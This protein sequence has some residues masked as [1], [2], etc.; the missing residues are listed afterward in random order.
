MLN[1]RQFLSVAALATG[2]STIRGSES[3]GGSVPADNPAHRQY[4]NDLARC[5]P[6][7]IGMPRTSALVTQGFH[8]IAP[9]RVIVLDPEAIAQF[10]SENA[11][12]LRLLADDEAA[13]ARRTGWRSLPTE[14]L[15]LIAG[16]TAR[17]AEHY[18]RPEL[19]RQWAR[20]LASREAI[21]S[22]GL[23]DGFAL[24]HEFQ[25]RGTSVR[26]DN[27]IADWWLIL[28]PGGVDWRALDDKPVYY[29]VCPVMEKV[30]PCSVLWPLSGITRGINSLTASEGFEPRDWVNRMVALGPPAAAREVNRL[31]VRGIAA[32]AD[33]PAF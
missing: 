28:L 33:T 9:N 7:I 15:N 18:A 12:L 2:S 21:G 11:E 30:E 6:K 23:G 5:N 29:M 16:L 4:L 19:A 31:L 17:M 3:L 22:T 10:D 13:R 32:C 26:T 20:N 8:P 1:R 14:K 27:G 24:P 25:S